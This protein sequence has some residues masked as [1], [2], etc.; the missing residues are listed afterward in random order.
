MDCEWGVEEDSKLLRGIYNHGI[1]SWEAMRTDPSLKLSDKIPPFSGCKGV[2]KKF[3]AR[4]E[5]LLK[6]LKR[7]MGRKVALV[8]F[9]F[10]GFFW[11]DSHESFLFCRRRSRRREL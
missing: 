3:Q 6:V 10:L 2:Y 1:G 11:I 9:S 7:H 8:R 5:Y 4:G